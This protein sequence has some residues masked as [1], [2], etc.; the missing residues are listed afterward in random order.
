MTEWK[1]L[2]IKDG[3]PTKW[4]WVVK[5]IQNFRLGKNTDIGYGTYIQAKNGVIIEDNVKI[6]AHCSI[7]SENT[8]D[9]TRGSILIKENAC[10]GANSV[11]L[12]RK[13]GGLLTIGKNAK[14]GALSLVKHN[15]PSNL[16]FIQKRYSYYIFRTQEQD[17]YEQKF[18]S[19]F[20]YQLVNNLK[21]LYLK[22]SSMN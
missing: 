17:I 6:A 3:E 13:D 9:N 18:S 5:N 12:P 10:I 19:D 15:I 7:Y 8:I 11:I 16:I 21:P 4:G 22:Y 14:V 20:S 2:V 1:Q